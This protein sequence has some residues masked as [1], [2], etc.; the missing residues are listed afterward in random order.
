MLPIYAQL[1][2]R[3]SHAQS[4][5]PTAPVEPIV[6]AAPAAGT[7]RVVAARLIALADRISPEPVARSRWQSG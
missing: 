3:A 4:A 5:L 6:Q 7:R 1:A 2:R